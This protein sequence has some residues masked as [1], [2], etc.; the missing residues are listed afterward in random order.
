MVDVKRA[1]IQKTNCLLACDHIVS[2]NA[3]DPRQ[4][5]DLGYEIGPVRLRYTGVGYYKILP[6]EKYMSEIMGMCD[7]LKFL[8][9]L[10]TWGK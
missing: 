3:I 6:A 2:Q 9:I 10:I 8:S 7:G 1:A 5:L 4:M